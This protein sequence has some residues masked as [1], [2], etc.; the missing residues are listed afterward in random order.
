MANI[1]SP[2]KIPGW[3]EYRGL[4]K[5]MRKWRKVGDVQLS[6][7]WSARNAIILLEVEG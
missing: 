4:L 2:D 1:T 7:L 3:A 6:S 5:R